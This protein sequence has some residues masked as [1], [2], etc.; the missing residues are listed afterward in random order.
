MK[1]L[2][3]LMLVLGIASMATASLQISVMGDPDPVD[4][5]I[6][7]APSEHLALDI[8]GVLAG[9][10]DYVFYL[11]LVNTAEGQLSTTPDPLDGTLQWGDL[12][13]LDYFT[14]QWPGYYLDVWIGNAGYAKPPIDGIAG[15][16]GDSSGAPFTGI[17]VDPIDFH[18]E[19]LGDAT[20]TL[21]SSPAGNIWT[22]EDTLIIH[23]I[24]EPMTMALLG[25][26][27]LF[28]RRRK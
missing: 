6:I 26:G 28:L 10:Q 25:L 12:S 1:K 22:L 13:K 8:H 23:Q 27:G 3:V 17:I 16:V 5:E 15:F 7:I 11:M 9:T 14:N 4:S 20:I 2:L 24:P 19:A 18:C 21:L